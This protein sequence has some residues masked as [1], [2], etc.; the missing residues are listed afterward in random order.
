M[1]DF[2]DPVDRIK[3]GIQSAVLNLLSGF[4]RLP[5]LEVL[6]VS[7]SKE[8]KVPLR[9]KLYSNVDLLYIPEGSSSLSFV[10]YLLHCSRAV[11]RIIREFNPHLIHFEEGMNFLLMRFLAGRRRKH[12]LTIHGITFAEAKLKPR[13]LQKLKWYQNGV[14]E[15]MLLP[16]HIIHISEYSKK[17]FS[18][19]VRDRSPVIFNSVGNSFFSVPTPGSTGNRLL[20]VGVINIRKNLL[21]L[22]EAM[23]QLKQQGCEYVLDVVGD[24]DDTEQYRDKVMTLIREKQLGNA[25]RFLG[26]KSQEELLSIY[27]MNDIVVLPSLQETLPVVVAEA[28]AAGRV[29]VAT[30]AGGVPEMIET[31]VDGFVYPKGDGEALKNILLA[32]HNNQEKVLEIG[33]NARK[34]AGL[35]FHSLV[36]ASQTLKYYKEVCQPQASTSFL[37]SYYLA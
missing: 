26:W 17:I 3:G 7:I 28:M 21:S 19:L 37:K 20:Y 29:M 5:E 4:S 33:K 24:F 2:P 12:V 6:V 30:D 25:V 35:K 18:S 13:L 8:N 16:D 1:P 11:R 22:L 27:T 31:G 34:S 36:V 9:R 32:L 15:R 23:H 14:V 10:N